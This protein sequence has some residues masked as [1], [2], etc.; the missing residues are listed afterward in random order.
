MRYCTR[1]E[2]DRG[3]LQTNE[4]RTSEEVKSSVG[5]EASDPQLCLWGFTRVSA[6]KAVAPTLK[7]FESWLEGLVVAVGASQLLS[8]R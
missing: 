1:R 4:A 6:D 2:D 8:D 5:G 3:C 7:E